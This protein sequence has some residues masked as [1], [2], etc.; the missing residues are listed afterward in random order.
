MDVVDSLLIYMKLEL[1]DQLLESVLPAENTSMKLEA[2]LERRIGEVESSKVKTITGEEVFARVLGL[3]KK[4]R[5][6]L[7]AH[8]SSKLL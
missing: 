5:I 6:E 8:V 3:C 2:D 7:D 4:Q 1:I